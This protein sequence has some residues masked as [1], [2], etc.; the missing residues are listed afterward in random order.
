MT[1][2]RAQPTEVDGH[3]FAS[4]REAARYRE[5]RL[6]ERAGK[7]VNLELQPKF[8]VVIN[9]RKI[10]TYI[11]DFRYV[12]LERAAR[13]GEASAQVTEDV[14]GVRTPLFIVKRKLV[15]A[16]YPGVVIEEVR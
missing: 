3:R 16:L 5:L 14:K 15:E 1:K 8:P 10:C 11:A 12:D 6:L 4:K 13:G 2:Y 9:G 7:I